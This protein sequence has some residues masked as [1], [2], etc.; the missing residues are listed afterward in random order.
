MTDRRGVIG[1]P[2]RLAVAVAVLSVCVPSLVYASE[3]FEADADVSDASAEVEKMISAADTVY[4]SGCGSRCTVSVSIPPGCE[5]AVGGERQDAHTVRI[6]RNGE[7]A[8]TVYT[9]HPVIRFV[10]GP[11]VFSGS[12]DMVFECVGGGGVYGVRVMSA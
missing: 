12:L 9:D 5:V 6:I 4:Y 2:V 10:G 8:K 7:V 1:L 11:A 3:T